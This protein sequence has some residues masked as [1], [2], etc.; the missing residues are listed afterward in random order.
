MPYYSNKEIREAPE[1]YISA[2]VDERGNITSPQCHGRYMKYN[3]GC[4]SG[5]CDDYVCE[6]CGYTVRIEWPD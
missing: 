2:K 4:S 3:G 5:C 6:E 1:G